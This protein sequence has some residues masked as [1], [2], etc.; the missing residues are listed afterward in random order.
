M[1][2][3][4]IKIKDIKVDPQSHI[5]FSDS[6]LLVKYSFFSPFCL[7]PKIFQMINENHLKLTG[8]LIFVKLHFNLDL[9]LTSPKSPNKWQMRVCLAARPTLRALL[10]WYGFPGLDSLRCCLI[11]LQIHPPTPTGPH[12]D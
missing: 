1:K 6:I 4:C 12:I 9:I 2:V 8:Q 11:D 7:D 10:T 3:L 5:E